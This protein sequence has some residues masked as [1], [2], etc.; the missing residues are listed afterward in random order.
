M[1]VGLLQESAEAWACCGCGC[2]CRRG[3]DAGVHMRGF[4]LMQCTGLQKSAALFCR[5]FGC[6]EGACMLRVCIRC[7]TARHMDGLCWAEG[8]GPGVMTQCVC[9]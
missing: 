7:G 2:M 5:V 1:D 8:V 6:V 4:R 9:A 3:A